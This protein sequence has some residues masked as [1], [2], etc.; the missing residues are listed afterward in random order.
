M[1]R[2]ETNGVGPRSKSMRMDGACGDM[3]LADAAGVVCSGCGGR[4]A[5]ARTG[6]GARGVRRTS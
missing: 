1:D 4:R 6:R 3:V 5:G 2:V